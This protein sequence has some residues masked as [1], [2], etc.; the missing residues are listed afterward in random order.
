MKRSRSEAGMS[1]VENDVEGADKQA[2]AVKPERDRPTPCTR[3]DML[4]VMSST[5]ECSR[6]I[7]R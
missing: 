7:S 3:I 1:Y 2:K 6:W 5:G 4:P